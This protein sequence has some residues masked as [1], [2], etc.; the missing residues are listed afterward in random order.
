MS[1]TSIPH[2]DGE[3]GNLLVTPRSEPSGVALQ[4]ESKAEPKDGLLDEIRF[5]HAE[6]RRRYKFNNFWDNVL[7]IA[8]LLLSVSIVAAGILRWGAISAILGAMVA[9]I[10]TAQRAY[11]FGQRANFYR[12]LIGQSENIET[13]VRQRLLSKQQA[14][15]ILK[16]L[17]LDFA[18]QFPRGSGFR[19]AEENHAPMLNGEGR[20]SHK[21]HA[22]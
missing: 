14:V 15:D 7:N 10:V 1:T 13:D 18:Q 19:A 9:A 3:H 12:I 20:K 5:F 21:H 17:R 6:C 2:L 11:P 22:Q 4:D 8:G 16:S